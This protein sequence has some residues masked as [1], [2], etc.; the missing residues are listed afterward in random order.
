MWGPRTKVIPVVL[1]ALGI[2]GMQHQLTSSKDP[3]ALLGAAR[4]LTE[5]KYLKC[6][7]K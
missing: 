7:L 2:I 5:E 3:S 1:G 6:R 4:I